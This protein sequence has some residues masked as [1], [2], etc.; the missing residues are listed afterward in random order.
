VRD[1][2]AGIAKENVDRIFDQGFTTQAVGEGY[3]TGLAVVRQIAQE[4]FRGR[5]GVTSE[6]GRGSTFTVT[7]PIPPQ[8]AS[9][10]RS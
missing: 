2:G 7:L 6:V 8:R 10:E 5:V 4:V 1:Q 3:G 9:S